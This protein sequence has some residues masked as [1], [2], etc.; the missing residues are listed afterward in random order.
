MLGGSRARCRGCSPVGNSQEKAQD[1]QRVYVPSQRKGGQAP[2]TEPQERVPQ[3][4]YGRKRNLAPVWQRMPS[5][6]A[7]DG[8]PQVREAEGSPSALVLH[9]GLPPPRPTLITQVQEGSTDL[10][11]CWRRAWRGSSGGSRGSGPSGRT[12]SNGSSSPTGAAHLLAAGP[13]TA[14]GPKQHSPVSRQG[15]GRE[16]GLA[17]LCPFLAV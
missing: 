8:A 5:G 16:P 2:G 1:S 17:Q 15:E 11:A 9:G 14:L 3:K 6:Q 10:S 4:A 12:G 13:G 7:A